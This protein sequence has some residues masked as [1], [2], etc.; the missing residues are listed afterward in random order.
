MSSNSRRLAALPANRLIT[1][2]AMKKIS[3]LSLYLSIYICTY[4]M[5]KWQ[6]YQ[7]DLISIISISLSLS[8]YLSHV[9]C[10]CQSLNLSVSLYISFTLFL[11]LHMYIK[12][13]YVHYLKTLCLSKYLNI[14]KYV[15]YLHI[16]NGSIYHYQIN[17]PFYLI[18][19][20]RPPYILV[21]YS[22]AAWLSTTLA[23]GRAATCWL[24]G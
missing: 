8:L 12:T 6:N 15:Y 7:E 3:S 20:S 21:T 9:I 10:L 14:Y 13:F 24:G 19:L 22:M 5:K 11:Y 17:L 16:I 2:R 4:C 1:Y 23:S 18:H